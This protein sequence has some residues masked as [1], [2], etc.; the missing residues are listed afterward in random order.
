MAEPR[1]IFDLTIPSV[2]TEGRVPPQA[3]DIEMAVLG[4]MLLEKIGGEY[5]LTELT[6]KVTSGANVEYHA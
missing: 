4:A 1:K 6:S 3:V 2:T 5:Y